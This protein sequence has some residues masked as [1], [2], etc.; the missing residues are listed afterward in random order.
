MY[1]SPPAIP[2]KVA[3]PPIPPRT[4]HLT[5]NYPN[6][7][8]PTKQYCRNHRRAASD[9]SIISGGATEDIVDTHPLSPLPPPVP[10]KKKALL[11]EMVTR[12]DQILSNAEQKDEKEKEKENENEKKEKM[13]EE[14][15]WTIVDPL[16]E[17]TVSQL[18]SSTA[19]TPG[20]QHHKWKKPRWARKCKYT[21]TH[22]H[23]T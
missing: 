17:S 4:R 14:E 21:N 18:T 16:E 19:S 22:T 11:A 6:E 2:P 1:Y 3:P 8:E 5:E 10:P 7:F 20:K 13:M 9:S 15:G 23:K 12:G